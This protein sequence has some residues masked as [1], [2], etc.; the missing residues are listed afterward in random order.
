MNW[1]SEIEPRLRAAA[2]PGPGDCARDPR[3]GRLD[4]RS[5]D[6]AGLAHGRT[7]LRSAARAS[8]R[9]SAA[10]RVLRRTAG[11]RDSR[12]RRRIR[13]SFSRP[14]AAALD[15]I[16][17][18]D[19]YQAN[20]SRRLAGAGDRAGR[21]RRRST[22]ACA[23][24]IP[25]RSRRCCATGI[26]RCMS[27]SPERLLSIR[28]DTVSTRPIAGTRPRGATPERR[29]GADRIALGQRE[30]ARRTRDA[31]RPGTQR[32]GPGVRRRLGAG[33]RVHERRDLRACA[34]H[35]LERQRPLAQR[36]YR[37]IEVIRALFPGGT[38]T[39]CPKVRCMEIIAELEGVGR[40]AYTGVHR[41]F[42]PRRQ[43]RSQHPDPHHH[44][45]GRTS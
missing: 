7:R 34:S 3:A 33:G 24:P 28:G 35:R 17:A 14:C 41:L 27:S 19:V 21:S 18:G 29:R 26:S 5:R 6:R 44:R 23:P 37:P 20:L 10:A 2:E 8:S 31:D 42:E 13:S 12:S 1:P 36:R 43:L 32:F 39:G 30:G 16:A 45:A 40:G 11:R 9:T 4:S 15:Y 25:V 38:I 22:S